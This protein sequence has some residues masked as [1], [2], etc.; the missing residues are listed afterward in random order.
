MVETMYAGDQGDFTEGGVRVPAFAGWPGMIDKGQLV[1]DIVRE[2]DPTRRG[3][4]LIDYSRIVLNWNGEP[5][6]ESD[7]YFTRVP[8]RG[9]RID[10]LECCCICGQRGGG[11]E[12]RRE[13]TTS[14][15]FR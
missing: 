4:H 2:T 15:I 3:F 6:N 10:R 8:T 14:D 5:W 7:P 1:E 11:T 13:R 12:N 9:S